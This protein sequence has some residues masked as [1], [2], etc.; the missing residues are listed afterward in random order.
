M[1]NIYLDTNRKKKKQKLPNK[2]T[3]DIIILEKKFN[4]FKNRPNE[5]KIKISFR[6]NAIRN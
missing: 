5:L 6:N 1:C 2:M 3:Q 4:R